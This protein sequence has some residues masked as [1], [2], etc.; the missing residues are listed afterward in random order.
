MAVDTPVFTSL[1]LQNFRSYKDFAV[2]LAPTVN[3]VVGPNASGKTNLLESILILC[4]N[5]SYRAGFGDVIANKQTWARID[6]D[7]AGGSRVVKLT[8][9]N[10]AVEKVYEINKKPKKRLSFNE[11]LPVILFE[12]E[13]MQLL[14]GSPEVRRSFLDEIL[15]ITQPDFGPNA[16]KYK[17]VLAQRNRLLKNGHMAARS[18]IFAWNVRLSELAGKIVAAR[19]KLVNELNKNLG[20]TYSSIAKNK[21][22]VELKYDTGLSATAYES[23]MLRR[24]EDSLEIDLARGFTTFGP[25]REDVGVFI[26]HRPAGVVASRGETRT[27]V[28]ALKLLALG[29]IEKARQQKPIVLLDDV[30]SELDGSR[31]KTL[32]QHL[33]SYQTIITT[34]DADVV[35]KEFMQTINRISLG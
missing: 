31:R 20:T 23:A 16:Q 6:G 32:T 7:M 33:N 11:K 22:T 4:G 18:Q 13:H 35:Q 19:I 34:T 15:T 25:H 14:T 27:L 30:F 17:R 21:T 1:R 24:L 28:I 12:P 10:D 26:N 3:I 8:K 29:L 5:S 9:N 2:E